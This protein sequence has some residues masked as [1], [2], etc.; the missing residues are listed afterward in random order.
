MIRVLLKRYGSI[1]KTS[2]QESL[3]LIRKQL[4]EEKKEADALV[5]QFLSNLREAGIKII[6]NE[7]SSRRGNHFR[8]ERGN[9]GVEVSLH[10]ATQEWLGVTENYVNMVEKWG[11]HWGIVL[12]AP[13]GQFWVDGRNFRTIVMGE[14]DEANG[15]NVHLDRFKESSSVNHFS[16]VQEFLTL[17]GLRKLP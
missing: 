10:L 17:S 1:R 8:L 6:K 3:S 16:S 4:L 9:A 7:G 2:L 14:L 11:D 13:E 15:Y 5:E 12:L